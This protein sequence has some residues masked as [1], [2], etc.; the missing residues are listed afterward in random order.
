M[1]P[2]PTGLNMNRR[3]FLGSIAASCAPA[4]NP[5]LLFR[6][7][8]GHA[9]AGAPSFDQQLRK[10]IPYWRARLDAASGIDVHGHNGIAVGDIDNDG[11]DEIYICQPGGLPNRLFRND[12]GGRLEDITERAGLAI[13][14]PTSS[15]LFLDLRNSGHQDLVVLRPDGPLL[16][17]ND[18]GGR[19]THKPGA[20][21]FRHPPEGSFTGMAA[22]DYDRDGRLDL[23]LCTYS[24][25]R[26]GNQYR[27]P[28]PYFDAQNGPANFLFHNEGGGALVDVTNDVGLDQNNN[29]FSFAPAWC[30]Y[31]GDG[32]PDLFVANDFGRKNL[33][34]NDKGHFRD[35]AAEAGVEDLG[36][37]MSASWFDYDGDGRPDLYVSNMW[38]E[39]GQRLVPEKWKRHAKGNSL[40]RNKGDGTF[41]DTGAREGVEMGRWAWSSDGVD[42]DNDGAPEIFITCG[43]LTNSSETDLEEFFWRKVA[44]VPPGPEYERGWNELSKAV[45][46]GFSEAGRQPNV[47]Y[48]RRNGRYE[49]SSRASGLDFADDSRAFA[50]TDLDGDGNLDLIL[51]SRLGPQVRVFQNNCG[52]KRN[53]LAFRL[54]GTKSNRDAIGARVEVDGQVKFVNAGSGYLSQHTKTLY[55]GSESA[56]RVRI[57]WPSGAHQEFNALAVGCLYEIQEGGSPHATPFRPRIELPAATV[58]G[59]NTARF[60]D[61]W[62]LEPVPL[63]EPT[64]PGIIR[65]SN[66][67]KDR[68]AQYSLFCRYLFDLHADI[69]LPIWFLVDDQSRAR[70]IYFTQPDQQLAPPPAE[71]RY[72]SPPERNY[73]ALGAAFAE[74]PEI[75]LQYLKLA[76]RDNGAVLL[77]IGKI[78]LAAQRWGLARESLQKAVKIIPDSPDAWN[79]LG[80]VELG[81]GS[82]KSAI[83]HFKK[84][85]ELRRDYIPAINNLAGAYAGAGQIDDAIAALRYGL[86]LA[87]ADESLRQNLEALMARK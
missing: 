86:Q 46:E 52:A 78:H 18:G 36:D 51:K 63:P 48:V 80:A 83:P 43:M 65:L 72:Y 57:D 24:F 19:F 55:F 69:K 77:A 14:D 66:L 39:V 61:T 54:R 3:L 13:L 10:G 7:I 47:F 23:Y 67:S 1:V 26:D 40:F 25:F 56:H 11:I 34:R 27:Y 50:V 87:P 71:G 33:Y 35:V 73:M 8:T 16:F 79:T 12:G 81:F 37:G 9:F 5:T 4:A 22:A 70:K 32:W 84:A 44:T 74:Y 53:S 15:A 76:P 6:E 29:R 42:F 2:A 58:A 82:P 31:N 85:I 59:E 38:S 41:E 21:R 45:H 64:P 75:A 28:T 49:D 60:A 62:L 30:D 68:A 20:F 17:L